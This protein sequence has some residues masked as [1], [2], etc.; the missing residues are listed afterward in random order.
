M[1]WHMLRLW[2]RQVTRSSHCKCLWSWIRSLGSCNMTS[3]DGDGLGT[4]KVSRKHS[5]GVSCHVGGI[6]GTWFP[7][8]LM[9]TVELGVNPVPVTFT[10]VPTGPE[11]GSRIMTGCHQSVT[12]NVF[13]A[14]LDPW[15]AL[16]V[17]SPFDDDK[18]T[19]KVAVKIPCSG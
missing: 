13:E 14:E 12:V 7:P 16:T 9:V 18:G 3:S 11:V 10:D 4:C 17:W 1:N 15:V 6:V 8:K 2:L 5:I 19:L